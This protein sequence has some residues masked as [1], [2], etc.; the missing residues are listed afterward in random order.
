VENLLTKIINN[1]DKDEY[2][3]HK[4]MID[5]AFNPR[6][7]R[8]I[9]PREI[10]SIINIYVN[11][12]KELDEIKDDL[13]EFLA[14]TNNGEAKSMPDFNF[15][16]IQRSPHLYENPSFHLVLRGDEPVSHTY[17]L[18]MIEEQNS[19]DNSLNKNVMQS[20]PDSKMNSDKNSEKQITTIKEGESPK[21]SPKKVTTYTEI[22]TGGNIL[23]D[24]I[25]MKA[26]RESMIHN[27]SFT[28]PPPI[29]TKK[30]IKKEKEDVHWPPGV[31]DDKP[32]QRVEVEGYISPEE[33]L[34]K[35]KYN[36]MSREEIFNMIAVWKPLADHQDVR[37]PHAHKSG[38]KI[39]ENDKL[40][41]KI[42]GL[43]KEIVYSL[44]KKILSGNFNLTTVSFP[45]KAMV[46]KSYLENIAL[47]TCYY[48]LYL[49]LA[50]QSKDPLQRLKYYIVASFAYYALTNSFAK[51]LNPVLGETMHG[52]YN[53]GTQVFLEQTSHHP[54][55][56]YI[57]CYGPN[58]S[59]KYYGPSIFSASAG[60]NSLTLTVKGWR[61]MIFTNPEQEI[62][63]TF[64]NESFD[65][66]FWG[67]LVHE[68][69]GIMDFTDKKNNIT[70]QVRFGKTKGKPSDYIDG[71]I[72][73][74]GVQVSKITGTYLGWVEFDKERYFDYRYT[75]PFKF[76]I[77]KSRLGSDFAYR[78]D[79]YYLQGGDI[80][81]A[82][83]EKEVIEVSQRGDAKIR[84]ETA[85]KKKKK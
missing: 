59:Y 29:S 39:P 47:G 76:N 77:E 82:Q 41:K 53:D 17:D 48:P 80:P 10:T 16:M 43:A 40:T 46:P 13:V 66:T 42:R 60:L 83:K 65:N 5:E 33:A 20:T 14:M 2:E 74:N 36:E 38:G 32:V 81:R 73:V 45:I 21:K 75:L 68:T 78:S 67:T 7:H 64:P 37:Y 4:G 55:I 61:K 18:P 57:L 8:D 51:P 1:M 79:L 84:K 3:K 9:D 70:A 26:V 62:Y 71:E 6:D 56:S 11:Q 72:K 52:H 15:S 31:K 30:S 19:S 27:T 44:G 22:N 63:S 50:S 24:S 25:G 85:E 58:N 34:N 28:H 49:N 12:T 23:N 69:L 35:V 54:P